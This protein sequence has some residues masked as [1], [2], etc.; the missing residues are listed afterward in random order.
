MKRASGEPG[1]PSG[2]TKPRKPRSNVRPKTD[3]FS[4]Q[5]KGGP[6]GHALAV[7]TAVRAVRAQRAFE[8]LR[9]GQTFRQI[10]KALDVSVYT[11]F[12]DCKRVLAEI[13][14]K[15]ALQADEYRAIH[16]QRTEGIV[17]SHY[18]NR[19][20]ARSASMVL[21]ALDRQAKLLGL[22]AKGDAGYSPEQVVTL[23][24]GMVA[25]FLE[26]VGDAELR[27]QYAAGV[28]RQLGGL[29]KGV[30][31]ETVPPE[32]APETEEP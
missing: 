10:A 18:G 3:V 29:A 22:D 15:L 19:K 28:R 23:V 7:R 26:V 25:L 5:H 20:D 32:P 12:E 11:A 2:E 4:R 6:P 17:Q 13:N 9:G 16:L 24:R 8:M 30:V 21:A 1:T 14:G 31:G 27:R